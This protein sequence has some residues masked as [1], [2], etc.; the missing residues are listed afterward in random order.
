L[1]ELGKQPNSPDKG[2]T[3]PR[4]IYIMNTQR[5][6]LEELFGDPDYDQS[7]LQQWFR[8][9]YGDYWRLM[10]NCYQETGR[11]FV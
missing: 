5:N 9:Q 10:W 3:K 11:I 2:I 6:E 1:N 8:H 7:Q 4:G